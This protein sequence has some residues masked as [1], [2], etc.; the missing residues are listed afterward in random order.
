MNKKEIIQ[1]ELSKMTQGKKKIK[2]STPC[3]IKYNG[4]FLTTGSKKTIW[5]SIG[6]AKNALRL[7]FETIARVY[8]YGYESIEQYWQNICKKHPYSYTEIKQREKEFFE[9]LYQEVE[10]VFV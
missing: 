1:E 3:R 8:S 4:E 2:K 6:A 7:H 5:P 9:D 10:F